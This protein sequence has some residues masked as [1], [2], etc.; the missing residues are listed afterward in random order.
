[1]ALDFRILG[2]PGLDNA[3]YVEVQTGQSMHRLLFDCGEGCLRELS[4]AR[5]Q[6]IESV[7]FSH[8]HMDHVAGFDTFFRHNYNRADTPVRIVGPPGTGSIMQHRF[9]GFVWNLAAEQPGEFLVTDVGAERLVTRRFLTAEAFATAH[10]RGER[11]FD[12]VVL[13]A[14]AFRVEARLMDHATPSVAYALR[15]KPHTNVDPAALAELGIPPG[16]WLRTLKEAPEDAEATLELA[17]KSCRLADLRRRLL[18]TTPG[19]SLAYL[20]DFR[21]DA[22]SEERLVDMLRGCDVLVCESNFRNA[23]RE[24]AR[25]NY[26]MTSDDVARLAVRA[27]AKELILF[28]LSDRY[29]REEWP[30]HLAEVRAVFPAARFPE[31]WHIGPPD[32][33]PGT[34]P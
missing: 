33:Q 4:V 10:P 20:T 1:M 16:P 3:L 6:A 31:H 29:P 25:R 2:R 26:H 23:D 24:L 28:H 34:P 11:P 19:Q 13:D 30:D 15:E 8:F 21:L 32:P 7:F 18:V 12:G 27:G 5:I 17:G 14:P 22:A 9:L